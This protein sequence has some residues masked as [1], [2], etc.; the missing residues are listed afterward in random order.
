M[1]HRKKRGHSVHTFNINGKKFS[2]RLTDHAEL[3]LSQRKIDLFQAVGL[4]LSLGQDKI[5]E[6]RD[7]NKDVMIMDKVNNFSVCVDIDGNI[8][9]IVTVID[10]ADIYVK[11]GTTAVQI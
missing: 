6:Y 5:L 7:S 2:I 11:Q 3:R 9:N 10:N 8:I 4:I 1:I